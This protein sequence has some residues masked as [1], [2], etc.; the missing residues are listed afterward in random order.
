MS[1]DEE[2]KR[3]Y[4]VV[5]ET[6][7]ASSWNT[8]FDHLNSTSGSIS[9]SRTASS[10]TTAT[11][12]GAGGVAVAAAA[13][14][15]P[16]TPTIRPQFSI[17]HTMVS[18][19]SRYIGFKKCAHCR[20]FLMHFAVKQD[21]EIY[22]CDVCRIRVHEGCLD[23][24][25]TSCLITT[26]YVGCLVENAVMRSN[27]KR[28][29]PTTSP[30]TSSASFPQSP[31][32]MNNRSE[33]HVHSSM[34][35]QMTSTIGTGLGGSCADIVDDDLER[36]ITWEDVTI[37][38]EDVEYRGRVGE[39]R[40]GTVYHAHYHGD[41]AVKFVNMNCVD[42]ERRV[43]VFKADVVTP[44]KNSRHD[45]LALFLG[46]LADPSTNTYAI[47]TNYYHHKTLYHRIHESSEDFETYW[48]LQISLQICQAMSYLHKKHILHKDLRS[49]NI[50][51]DKANK[52]VVADFALLKL[53]R[54]ATPHRTYSM[55][56]PNH[57]LDYISPEIAGSLTIGSDRIVEHTELPFSN[58]SDVYS[59]GTIFFELL[60]RKMPS[61]SL[62]WEI[63]LYEKVIGTKAA[64]SRID[65]Q[66]Q[67]IDTQLT[68]LLM[69]C[70]NYQSTNRPQ[71][72][73]VVKSLNALIRKKETMARRSIAHE[74]PL[75]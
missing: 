74:N 34:M 46:Y 4:S 40:F 44:Y 31:V 3:R 60:M 28:W 15:A 1:R 2:Q 23:H 35:S 47:V 38:P 20:R 39:G 37:R 52:V 67:R 43:D 51:I 62:P 26:Q 6:T 33:S 13:A 73:S 53:E 70:W 71:F 58:E 5:S 50:L 30:T 22:S 65:T 64:L 21:Q 68:E 27:K 19:K 9:Q 18:T 25:T 14:A 66:T 11:S 32:S 16:P 29:D 57:W 7:H 41:V 61:G 17:T 49:K 36:M 48:S 56:V 59:F 42:E 45:H 69:K 55:M 8:L 12:T 72:S 63:K 54:L 10:T 24:L 75:F